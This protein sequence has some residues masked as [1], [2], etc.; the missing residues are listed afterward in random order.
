M[1][2]YLALFILLLS[3]FEMPCLAN[4]FTASTTSGGVLNCNKSSNN[5]VSCTGSSSSPTAGGIVA[6]DSGFGSDMLLLRISVIANCHRIV[7]CITQYGTGSATGDFAIHGQTEGTPG[8]LEFRTLNIF[9]SFTIPDLTISGLTR[10]STNGP[11]FGSVYLFQYE[12]PF[13]IA[14]AF[15]FGCSECDGT[16]S[17]RIQAPFY[18][19]DMDMNPI[20][21]ISD[22]LEAQFIP[23]AR[24]SVLMLS[25]LALLWL[26]RVAR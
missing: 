24:T 26:R 7:D 5:P 20:R 15:S 8:L 14:I 11:H 17:A 9:P 22:P 2:R 19:Y 1:H 16:G 25:G 10:V 23:E 6:V 13:Q 12:V 21:Q 3:V 4:Y 18:I